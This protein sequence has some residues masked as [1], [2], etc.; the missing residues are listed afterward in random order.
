[1]SQELK[2]H[3]EQA[4]RN[5]LQQFSNKKNTDRTVQLAQRAF[6]DCLASELDQHALYIVNHNREV[7]QVAVQEAWIKILSSADKYDPEK[8]SVK[9]W[10]KMITGRC[11]IDE[12]RRFYKHDMRNKDTDDQSDELER[13]EENVLD[14]MVCPLPTGEESLHAKQVQ[15]AIAQCL[16]VLPNGK[17][18]NY[19][20]A[21]KLVLDEDLSYQ[22]MSD[23]LSQQSV[24]QQKLN[25]EQVRGWVRQ[26]AAKMKSCISKK[27]GRADEQGAPR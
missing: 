21:M 15:R 12:L 20:L 18:P 26:A 19:R 23:V 8:S 5:M 24:K 7:A 9:T 25:A 4:L 11:A 27:L 16:E 2:H 13:L 17:G 6:Y 3:N 1:V 14:D 22:E 10:A